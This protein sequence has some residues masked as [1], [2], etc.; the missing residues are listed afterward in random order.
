MYVRPSNVWPL[1]LE[2]SVTDKENLA[3]LPE[4]FSPVILNPPLGHFAVYHTSLSDF[5]GGA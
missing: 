4:T 5:M 2:I 3:A 1:A